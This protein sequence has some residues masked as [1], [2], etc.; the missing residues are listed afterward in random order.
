MKA[1]IF[2]LA[3]V[4]IAF[5]K[6]YII[7]RTKD[8]GHVRRRRQNTAASHYPNKNIRNTILWFL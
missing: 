3:M 8:Q 1:T 4:D 6:F 7:F 5:C 2:I